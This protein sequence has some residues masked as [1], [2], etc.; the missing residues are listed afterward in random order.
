MDET[1]EKSKKSFSDSN[2]ST[3]KRN[4][5]LWRDALATMDA[6]SNMGLDF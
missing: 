1:V 4:E 6:S 2:T 3:A 5:A